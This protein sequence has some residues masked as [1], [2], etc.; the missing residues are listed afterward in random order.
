M[1]YKAPQK[2][3]ACSDKYYQDNKDMINARRRAR[4]A[5]D[6]EKEKIVARIWRATNPEKIAATTAKWRADPIYIEKEK[7]RHRK[8]HEDN[9]AEAI[10]KANIRRQ[11]MKEQQRPAWYD[12]K[13]VRAIYKA[14]QR[15]N[16][17]AGFAKWH[18]DHIVPLKGKNVRGLHVQN[19]LRIILASKN[20][21]KY[22][23]LAA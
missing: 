20:K 4:Y 10:E 8:R 7:A 21:A 1:P 5:Q 22:N 2:N 14:M 16:K 11:R 23:K 19:N 3:K 13:K 17:V 9:P 18:V 6:P 15:R 12:A